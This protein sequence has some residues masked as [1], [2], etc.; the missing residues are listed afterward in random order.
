MAAWRPK[1]LSPATSLLWFVIHF[2]PLPSFSFSMQSWGCT[3]PCCA[4]R[5]PLLGGSGGWSLPMGQPSSGPC[6][7]LQHLGRNCHPSAPP[8]LALCNSTVHFTNCYQPPKK[9]SQLIYLK[10]G[11]TNSILEIDFAS[12]GHRT[13]FR[14]WL[15]VSHQLPASALQWNWGGQR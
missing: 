4:E 9:S 12:K 8:W 7:D 11:S 3:S 5:Q 13:G 10:K 15:P 6:W 1:L 14:R 2:L